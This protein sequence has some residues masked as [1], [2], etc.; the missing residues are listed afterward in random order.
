MK[1][2]KIISN[3]ESRKKPEERWNFKINGSIRSATYIENKMLE[4]QYFKED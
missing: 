2:F 1:N 4:K 3:M